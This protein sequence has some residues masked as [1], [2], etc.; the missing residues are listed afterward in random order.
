MALD[1]RQ[2]EAREV[3]QLDDR[4]VAEQGLQVGRVVTAGAEL[5]QVAGLV[6]GGELN[7]AKPVPGDIEPH[8]LGVDG[9]DFAQVESVGQVVVMQLNVQVA[10]GI[11][12]MVAAP[13]F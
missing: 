12:M 9:N 10:T 5:H 4:R 1:H 8:G 3:E 2:V 7:Q 11:L 13:A 6:A